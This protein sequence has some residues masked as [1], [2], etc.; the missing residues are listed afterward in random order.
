MFSVNSTSDIS[1]VHVLISLQVQRLCCEV[2]F[3]ELLGESYNI[4][5]YM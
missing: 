4:N 5:A 1:Q 3:R 2:I